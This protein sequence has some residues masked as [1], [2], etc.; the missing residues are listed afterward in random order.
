MFSDPAEVPSLRYTPTGP[1]GNP[2]AEYRSPRK[3]TCV[4][5]RAAPTPVPASYTSVVPAAVPS[6]LYSRVRPNPDVQKN[7]APPYSIMPNGFD[8]DRPGATSATRTVPSAVPSV[9]HSSRPLA[10]AV[11][12]K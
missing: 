2:T 10:S 1:P 12:E 6:V 11:A 3:I 7:T 4:A 8:E 5:V 9:F